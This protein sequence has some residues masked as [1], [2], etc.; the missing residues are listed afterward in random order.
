MPYIFVPQESTIIITCTADGHGEQP[1][2]S[3]G[4]ANESVSTHHQFSTRQGLLNAHGVYELPPIETQGIPH[5]LRLLIN[6]TDV[7]NQ[8]EILCTGHDK[9]I[10]TT[11]FIISK[12]Y[13]ILMSC[14]MV[15]LA[16]Y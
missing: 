16:L 4:L 2:W 15:L 3:V 9:S 5:T 7:N 13:A 1:F 12:Y 14:V 11:L 8:T 6:N 10:H